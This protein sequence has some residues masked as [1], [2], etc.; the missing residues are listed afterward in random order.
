MWAGSKN[1][2]CAP[3]RLAQCA[4]QRA[5]DQEPLA[6]T[7]RPTAGLARR[8]RRRPVTVSAWFGGHG[9]KTHKKE[10]TAENSTAGSRS[11]TAD[12][13]GSPVQRTRRLW[14]R[15]RSLG[16]PDGGT[17]RLNTPPIFHR[18]RRW[19]RLPV[20]PVRA[21]RRRRRSTHGRLSPAPPWSHE[22]RAERCSL[23][24]LFGI[25]PQSSFFFLLGRGSPFAITHDGH[26]MRRPSQCVLVPCTRVRVLAWY[27]GGP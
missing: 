8:V 1:E 14:R 9:E 13:P 23:F 27:R 5:R 18:R 21:V 16:H 20:E 15:R 17:S 25:A 11:A 3:P 4:A 2:R 24:R 19:S 12:A 22:E 26:M 6:H 10:G 7:R